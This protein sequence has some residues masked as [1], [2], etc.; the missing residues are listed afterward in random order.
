MA[1]ASSRRA[2]GAPP[3]GHGQGSRRSLGALPLDRGHDPS[4]QDAMSSQRLDLCKQV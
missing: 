1:A 4:H 3:L 2:L